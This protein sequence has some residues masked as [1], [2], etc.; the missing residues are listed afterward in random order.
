MPTPS[1]VLRALLRAALTLSATAGFLDAQT[2]RFEVTVSSAAT[3]KPVTG[4]LVLFIT[5]DNWLTRP[6]IGRW[7][8]SNL[9]RE[10]ELREAFRAAGFSRAEL[11]GFPLAAKHLSVWGH[12]V[13]ALR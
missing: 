11:P 10:A 7:W 3:S 9:Y 6:L 8:Q 12:V 5:R 13:D 4:R 2:P 1:V